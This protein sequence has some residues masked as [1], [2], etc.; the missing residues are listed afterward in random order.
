MPKLFKRPDS[1]NVYAWVTDPVTKRKR[2]QSTREANRRTAEVIA[3]GRERAAFDSQ[4]TAP[5]TLEAAANAFLTHPDT[6]ALAAGTQEMYRKKIGVLFRL[7]GRARLLAS[8]DAERVDWYTAERLGE[9]VKRAT[10]H[11]ERT[12]L[13]CILK[14]ARRYKKF[15]YA[16]DEVFSPF[17]GKSEPKDRWCTPEEAWAIIHALPPHRGAVVAFHVA[18][19]TNLS[20][21][22]RA[23]PE[24]VHKLPVDGHEHTVVYIRGTKRATRKRTSPVFVWGLPFLAFARENAGVTKGRPMFQDWTKAMRWDLKRVTARLGIPG[25]SSNDFRRTYSQWLRQR[26]VD[27]QLIGPAMGHA[28]SRMVETTYGRL[29]PES[30]IRLIGVQLTANSGGTVH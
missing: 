19:G 24:D 20:E 21:C 3:H 2:R 26:G 9:D 8:I 23:Q 12:A 10:I 27:P 30:L 15:P 25:V 11:K 13:R 22:L 6:L 7:L 1:P 16:L 18:T 5:Q 29:P 4:H 28:D 14:L 17:S